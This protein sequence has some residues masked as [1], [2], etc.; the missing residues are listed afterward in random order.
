M[1]EISRLSHTLRAAR[2]ELPCGA[3][4]VV[5]GEGVRA[6]GGGPKGCVSKKEAEVSRHV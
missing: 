5:G 4:G 6:G 3:R 2:A 1:L